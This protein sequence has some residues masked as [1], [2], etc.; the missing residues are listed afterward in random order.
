VMG[1]CM[2]LHELGSKGVKSRSRVN[3]QWA[4]G[5]GQW[6]MVNGQWSMDQAHA[7]EA[8]ETGRGAWE[9]IWECG[10]KGPN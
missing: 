10:T 1:L 9:G 7:G 5:N 8:W 6:S 3:G 4:M 2:T